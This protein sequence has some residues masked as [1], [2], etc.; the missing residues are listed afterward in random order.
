ME[1]AAALDD[2]VAID[3]GHAAPAPMLVLDASPT[4]RTTAAGAERIGVWG[5]AAG[6]IILL[7]AVIGI[8]NLLE[9]SGEPGTAGATPTPTVAEGVLGG[10][11]GPSA[12]APSATAS[13]EPRSS[14]DSGPSPTTTPSDAPTP[15]PGSPTLEPDTTPRP[16]S[17]PRTA[18]PQ[19]TASAVPTPTAS[20]KPTASPSP[21]PTPTPSP[22]PLPTPEPTPVPTP[23]PTEPPPDGT[24]SNGIDDDEDT[25][26]DDLDPGCISGSSEFDG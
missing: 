10:A 4:I 12:G 16:T 23:T 8:T 9:R 15:R 17:P 5:P 21:T 13:T 22:T 26:V 25:F 11:G 14:D 24:C 3:V 6:A 20:P 18:T 7:V 2:L 1:A 19:P